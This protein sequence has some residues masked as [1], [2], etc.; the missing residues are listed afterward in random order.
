MGRQARIR[1]ERS[2][3][4]RRLVCASMNW[5]LKLATILDIV[6]DTR[7]PKNR[8]AR[9]DEQIRRSCILRSVS[10]V[11]YDIYGSELK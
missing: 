9:R 8:R 7:L 1:K 2:W 4:H 6:R 11:M 3:N 5:V 10:N